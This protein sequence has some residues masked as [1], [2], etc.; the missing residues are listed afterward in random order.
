MGTRG[1]DRGSSGGIAGRGAITPRKKVAKTLTGKQKL[2]L[3][4]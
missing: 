3:A 1:F 4:A 2:A